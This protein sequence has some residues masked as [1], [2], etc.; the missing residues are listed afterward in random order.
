MTQADVKRF[1]TDVVAFPSKSEAEIS[2][3]ETE[4]ESVEVSKR[5]I[6]TDLYKRFARLRKNIR[7]RSAG[8][9]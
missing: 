6:K 2:V 1:E 3:K 8:I 5:T 4:T 7:K 9:F